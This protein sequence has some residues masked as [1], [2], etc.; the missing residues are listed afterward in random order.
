MVSL[1]YD[2]NADALYVRVCDSATVTRTDE[3]DSGTLVDL[4]D[5]G[6]VVGIEVV[7][8]GRPW[9]LSEILARYTVP[10]DV[11]TQLCAYFPQ[12]GHSDRRAPFS[13]PTPTAPA[14]PQPIPA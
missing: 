4:D 7:S 8:P 6:A 13:D 5:T 3:I 12:T 10:S 9:P 11:R 1:D 14:A 2:L